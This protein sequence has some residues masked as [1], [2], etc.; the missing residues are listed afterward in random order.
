MSDP[1]PTRLTPRQSLLASEGLACLLALAGLCLAAAWYDLAPV[2]A[3]P[4]GDRAP[5]PW[6]FLGLQELLRWLPAK[7]AGL[8]LPLGGL[9]ILALLPWLS[10]EPGPELPSWQRRPRPAEALAWMVLLA[11]LGITLVGALRQYGG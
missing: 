2:G 9:L 8:G 5:A 4:S 10:K 1:T 6:L 7:A 3:A 11:G